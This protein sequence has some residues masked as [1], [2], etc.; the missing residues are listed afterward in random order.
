MFLK[1]IDY[2]SREITLFHKND[3]KHSN[4][5]SGFLTIMAYS[6]VLYTALQNLIHLLKRNSFTTYFYTSYSDEK[7]TMIFSDKEFFHYVEFRPQEIDDSIINIIG[8][9]STPNLYFPGETPGYPSLNQVNEYYYEKCTTEDMEN[10]ENLISNKETFLKSYCL[11]KMYDYKTNKII[12]K[13]DPNFIFPK[14]DNNNTSIYSIMVKKC[15]NDENTTGY[16]KNCATDDVINSVDLESY[17]AYFHSVDR[18]IDVSNYKNPIKDYIF[19]KTISL[20]SDG[21]FALN[22]INY[23]NVVINSHEGIIFESIK[24]SH[25][26]VF[27]D[28]EILY[29][30]GSVKIEGILCTAE[31]WNNGRTSIYVREYQSLLDTISNIG[32]TTEIIMNIF[33]FFNFIFN[34]Y[35]VYNDSIDMYFENK[36]IYNMSKI[37]INDTSSLK[38]INV[39]TRN[40]RNKIKKSKFNN[41]VLDTQTS[42]PLRKKRNNIPDK[43]KKITNVF[44]INE[45]ST[46]S[47]ILE[48]KNFYNIN[49]CKYVYLLL[50]KFCSKNSKK[51]FKYR[52]LR[53][54][55]VSEDLL[56]KVY[57]K[58][59][60]ENTI[61]S[62]QSMKIT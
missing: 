16:K 27:E 4:Y 57:F 47:K 17:S 62:E 15:S 14:I 26:V 53:E 22:K 51:Y 32:G 11:H 54:E 38:K 8:V 39:N 9:E 3:D 28:N 56:Y 24:Q 42:D 33:Y 31:Y 12:N 5:I 41:L 10:H 25:T 30:V 46:D 2:I 20:H 44:T 48:E 36:K 21:E 35:A 58:L 1:K 18:Y 37:K 55:I 40:K 50:T 34:S 60:D 19:H 7:S 29:N 6:L 43:S 49:F 13:K 23:I 61:N 45:G 52:D 59:L